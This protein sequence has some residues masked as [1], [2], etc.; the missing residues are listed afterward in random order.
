MAS[1]AMAHPGSLSAGWLRTRSFDLL[2]IVGTAALALA[3]AAAMAAR[4]ELFTWLLVPYLWLLGYPHLIA[5]YT[6]TSFDRESLW[7]N[8]FLNFGLPVLIVGTIALLAGTVGTW[9]LVTT[10]LYWQW[11]HF[12]RQSYGVSRAYVRKAGIALPDER[13]T[14]WL[15]YL[16]PIWGILY[17]SYQAPAMYLGSELRVIPI[18][19][20]VVAAVG[21][22]TSAL[23]GV[24][25]V[26]RFAAWLRGEVPVAHTMYM[27]SH[28][29]IFIASYLLIP[30]INHGWLALSVWHSAQYLLFVWL[31]NA[32]RF[33]A[34]I[35]PKRPFLSEISQAHRGLRFYFVCFAL[36]TILFAALTFG[37][38]AVDVPAIPVALVVYYA[39]NFHHYTVDGLVWRSKRK[40]ASISHR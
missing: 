20:A 25:A 35:D 30:D 32:N 29:A 27:A 7:T 2:F 31:W 34:G 4:A 6:R 24:W 9:P 22:V 3:A 37:L 18:P 5:T 38:S 39:I 1:T 36:S 17:R 19:Y 28:F 14:H 13:L 12:T 33:R 10:Y 8:R 16:V 21:I 26:G 40:P 15:V 11:F 23:L